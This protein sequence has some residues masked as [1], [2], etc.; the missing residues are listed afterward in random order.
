MIVLSI[1]YLIFYIIFFLLGLIFGII[2]L[3]VILFLLSFRKVPKES[4]FKKKN[5][6]INNTNHDDNQGEKIFNFGESTQLNWMNRLLWRAYPL[7]LDRHYIKVTIMETLDQIPKDI[8]QIKK[9]KLAQFKTGMTPLI[10]DNASIHAIP[11]SQLQINPTDSSNNN[12]DII[13][14]SSSSTFIPEHQFQ[15]QPY[16]MIRKSPRKFS[17]PLDNLKINHSKSSSNIDINPQQNNNN[18]TQ[19]NS[20]ENKTQ[21]KIIDNNSNQSLPPGFS[22][23]KKIIEGNKNCTDYLKFCFHFEPDLEI[24]AEVELAIRLLGTIPVAAN[25]K[26]HSLSG[27]FIV[28]IPPKTGRIS[29]GILESTIINFDITAQLGVISFNSEEWKSTWTSLKNWIH[30]FLHK[31]VINIPLE[32]ILQKLANPEN[33]NENENKNEDKKQEESKN[34]FDEERELMLQKIKERKRLRSLQN[35]INK[36]ETEKVESSP[37][38]LNNE[39]QN[40]NKKQLITFKHYMTLWDYEF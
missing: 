39:N 37:Q 36:P 20:G 33:E 10:L 13:K 11:I 30:Y 27:H 22:I 23:I 26:L 14:K 9:L 19:T 40:Q 7:L 21:T 24:G 16:S 25:F 32:E 35:E 17:T 38:N 8:P 28:A 18:L 6:N 3:I 2:I 4:K 15:Q 31:I 29:I 34:D 1:L 12:N 5:E